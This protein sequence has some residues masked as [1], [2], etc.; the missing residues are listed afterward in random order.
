MALVLLVV[1]LRLKVRLGRAMVVSAAALTI[2]LGVSPGEFRRT[3]VE[4]W[5]DKPLSQTTGY[6]FVALT[7]LVILVNVLGVAMKETGVSQRLAPA[8]QGLFK[9]RRVALA[10]IPMMMGMLPT[11]V[12]LCMALSASYFETSLTKI[13][14]RVIGPVLFI[15]GAGALMAA[16]FG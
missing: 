6:L 15:A 7:A 16:F 14:I 8:L 12:H 11:P 5:R 3:V 1:L 9:S 4:E 13:V 10:A 2:L